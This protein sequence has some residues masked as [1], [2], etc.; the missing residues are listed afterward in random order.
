M[1]GKETPVFLLFFFV[2]LLILL[3][4]Y[5]VMTRKIKVRVFQILLSQ[6]SLIFRK[7]GKITAVTD[8]NSINYFIYRGEPMGYQFELLNIL[9]DHLNLQA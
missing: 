4:R 6:I 8:Y 9:A 3:F 5:T 1:G 2:F 7:R